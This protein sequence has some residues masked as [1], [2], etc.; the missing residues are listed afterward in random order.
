MAANVTA[1]ASSTALDDDAEALADEV[2]ALNLC[3]V[4]PKF[5]NRAV[6]HDMNQ[7]V[8]HLVDS[9]ADLR[10]LVELSRKQHTVAVD[11]EGVNLGASGEIVLV[12]LS[13]ARAGPV[14]LVDVLA[15]GAEAAFARS[16]PSLVD[17]LEAPHTDKLF[18]D[19]RADVAALFHQHGVLPTRIRDMQL[20]DVVDR[21]VHGKRL[22][23]L[24]GF[25]FIIDQTRHAVLSKQERA[26]VP[27]VK[28]RAVQLFAPDR[29]GSYEA[30]KARPLPPL[31]VSYC[32]DARFMFSL[33]DSY[34]KW[35]GGRFETV[36][37]DVL[38]A[39]A[40]RRVDMACSPNYDALKAD[41]DAMVL[42]D[43][44]LLADAQ[45]VWESWQASNPGR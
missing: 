10:L 29:G 6:M 7:L 9:K 3:I 45:A 38:A 35:K 18:F 28:A 31:L 26:T 19:L 37:G 24:S 33:H 13:F 27:D 4:P 44:V 30:W 43:P 11:L 16:S 1:A 42:S 22:E 39:A 12:Q 34:G 5:R 17:I 23:R 25:G 15:L 14:F 21:L 8:V 20:W 40:A 41:R 2:R 32:T 36:F